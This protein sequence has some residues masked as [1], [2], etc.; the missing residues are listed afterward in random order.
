MHTH[1]YA[2]KFI[3]ICFVFFFMRVECWGLIWG[4]ILCELKE[5]EAFMVD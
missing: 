1:V 3:F 5:Y 4:W 2:Y